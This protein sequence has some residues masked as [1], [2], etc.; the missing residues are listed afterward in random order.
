MK[1]VGFDKNITVMEGMDN[2]EDYIRK[3]MMIEVFQK[4][5]IN[6]V[7]PNTRPFAWSSAFSD[8]SQLVKDGMSSDEAQIIRQSITAFINEYDGKK[9]FWERVAIWL[10]NWQAEERVIVVTTHLADFKEKIGSIYSM[11]V[12]HNNIKP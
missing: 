2:I 1:L 5:V 7:D 4:F 10:F 8:I 6:Y 3:T 9:P 11:R 12:S